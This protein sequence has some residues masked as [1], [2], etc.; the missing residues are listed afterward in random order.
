MLKFSVKRHGMRPHHGDPDAS[1]RNL[2][3]GMIHDFATFVSH[4]KLFLGVTILPK[5][6]DVRD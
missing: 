1:A 5:L 2:E 4:L 3:P 6:I